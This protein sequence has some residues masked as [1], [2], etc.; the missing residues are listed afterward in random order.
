M[1]VDMKPLKNY[2]YFL[3]TIVFLVP[4]DLAGQ[5]K[6]IPV[7]TSSKEALDLFIKGRDKHENQELVQA[8][9]LFDQAIQKD[10]SF[11]LAYLYRSI[12]GGGYNVMRQNIDKAVSLADKVSPGEKLEIML[13]QAFV[14]R[15][16][17]KQKEYVDQLLTAFPSDKRVHELAGEYYYDINDF[18]SALA[19]FNK[20][21]EI[22]KDFAP[23]YNMIGYCQSALNNFQDAEQ[24]FQTYIKLVPEKPNPYD[25]YAELLLKEGKYDESIAQYKKALEKDPLFTTSLAGIGNNFV[26][27]G[28]FTSARKYYQDYFDK[29]P[30]VVG[31]LDAL[32]LKAV[33]F[34]Y[35]G[36]QEEAGKTFEEYRTLAEK[37]NLVPNLF[38]SYA[39]QGFTISEGGNPAEGMKYLQKADELIGKANLPEATKERLTTSSMLWHFY[40]LAA[41]DE[42]DK[43]QAEAEKC[44]TQ[45]AIRKDP[46]EM[47]LLNSLLGLYEIKKGDYDQAIGFLS[48]GDNTNP[49]TWYY[50][51]VAYS[52][53]GDKQDS[54]RLFDKISKCNVNSLDLALVRKPAMQEL[55]NFGSAK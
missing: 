4:F 5:V 43:A 54:E 26:F 16:G 20:A 45:V 15:N 48:K 36:N 19:Q 29:A 27:K 52:K 39:Y 23:V 33:T 49:M 55:N 32:S 38:N 34:I 31:K 46:A 40:F 28:D 24:A 37:E 11:A 41:N 3:L 10:P 42:L 35:E 21:A 1:E 12:S 22:D 9:S 30:A 13:G 6:E 53:K 2:L 44:K 51:A 8:A 50:T 18:Q 17:E 47:M 14:D 25:S 7:T